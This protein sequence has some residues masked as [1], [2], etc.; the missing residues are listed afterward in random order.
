MTPLDRA[1]R[2]I[3][4]LLESLNIEYAIV[5]G[6]LMKIIGHPDPESYRAQA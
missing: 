2:D 1:V 5:G 6:I 4:R 3:T